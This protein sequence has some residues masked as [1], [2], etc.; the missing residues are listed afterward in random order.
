MCQRGQQS[1]R[2]KNLLFGDS[3][4]LGFRLEKDTHSVELGPHLRGWMRIYLAPARFFVSQSCVF[5]HYLI[6][7]PALQTTHPL[8]ALRFFFCFF[9]SLN[10]AFCWTRSRQEAEG[11]SAE[12]K[13]V[14]CML[15]N[16]QR[17][18]TRSGQRHVTGGPD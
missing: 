4:L 17:V 13:K 1:P 6:G 2:I 5:S 18:N 16:L 14:D 3:C 7:I 12:K 8:C 15:K 10:N 9:F 11:G